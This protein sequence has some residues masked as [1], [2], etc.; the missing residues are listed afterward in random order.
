M[1][2]YP[3]M[4][5]HVKHLK[6]NTLAEI[7]GWIGSVGVLSSYFLLST[8]VISGESIIYYILSGI[9]GF[10]LAVITYR[11]KAYQSFIVNSTFTTL[12]IIAIARLTLFS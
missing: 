10:G 6:K 2:H 5:K 4:E 8:G 7:T 1:I 9:G 3:V 12:A 11:H